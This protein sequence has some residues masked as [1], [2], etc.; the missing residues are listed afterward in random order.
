MSVFLVVFNLDVVI[1]ERTDCLVVCSQMISCRT[2][3]FLCCVFFHSTLY[4]YWCIRCFTLFNMHTVHLTLHV[5][6][7]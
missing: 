2:S 1:D 3:G 6:R 7:D 5:D 4:R